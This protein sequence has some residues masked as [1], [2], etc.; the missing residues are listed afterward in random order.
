MPRRTP[1]LTRSTSRPRLSRQALTR[2]QFADRLYQLMD[3]RNWTQSELARQA[4]IERDSVSRYV[5]RKNLPDQVNLNKMAEAF[6]MSPEDLLPNYSILAIDIDD[7][8]PAIE[9]RVVDSDP[10]RAL[11]IIRREV[12][13]IIA[14][15]VIALLGEEIE[16]SE[17]ILPKKR[18]K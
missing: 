11:L 7:E 17:V 2:K 18:P 4:G 15:K 16:T 1:H 6:K 3:D 14:A 12:P 10:T 13:T 9:M 5:H 8:D